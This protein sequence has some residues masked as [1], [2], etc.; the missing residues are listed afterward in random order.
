MEITYHSKSDSYNRCSFTLNW[1]DKFT[2]R[3]RGQCFNAD[4]RNH[5]FPLPEESGKELVEKLASPLLEKIVSTTKH[6]NGSYSATIY[7][8]REDGNRNIIVAGTY[9]TKKQIDD[10][11][12]RNI[13]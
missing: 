13:S 9:P 11:I 10:F 2:G 12:E 7:E 5:G 8:E 1:I 4:P 6:N 3:T